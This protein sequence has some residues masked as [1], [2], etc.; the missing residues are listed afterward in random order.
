MATRVPWP[1]LK[2]LSK[3]DQERLRR[4]F[5]E[6]CKAIDASG[7]TASL[8]GIYGDGFDGVV[9]FD[10]SSTVLGLAP[11]AGLYTLTR[12]IYLAAGSQVS[13][14]AIIHEKGFRIFCNGTF[15]IGASAMV[16]NTARVRSPIDTGP[17]SI[18]NGLIGGGETSSSSALVDGAGLANALGGNG[19][20]GGTAPAGVGQVAGTV[21]APTAALGGYPRNILLAL[22]AR[23]A[24]AATRYGGGTGGGTGRYSSG[25]HSGGGGSGG[26]V[27]LISAAV[28]IN[29]GTIAARGQD[30]TSALGGNAG[31]GGGGG[32]GGI[33]LICGAGSVVGTTDVSGGAAGNPSG[34]GTAGAAGSAGNVFTLIG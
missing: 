22:P 14:S 3:Q 30:A 1:Y 19:G 7:G 6:L 21:T 5:D 34:T 32:G 31:G 8:N 10:G 25:T 11:S 4:D 20:N 27:C 17:G 15:T 26:G 23:T 28:L 16:D 33:I 9:N 24:D 12:D 2:S 13:G 18:G 29:N